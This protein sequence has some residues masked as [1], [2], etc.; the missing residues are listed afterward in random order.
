M[1]Q[2]LMEDVERA[3]APSQYAFATRAGCE[4]IAHVLQGITELDPRT[5]V[6]SLGAISAYDLTHGRP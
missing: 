5:T 3:T 4:C 2:Q 1:S 6:L